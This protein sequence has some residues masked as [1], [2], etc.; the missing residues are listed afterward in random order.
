MNFDILESV[1]Q[2]RRSCKP[3]LMNG[4][5]ID[6]SIIYKLL[7]LADWAPTHAHTEPWRFIVFADDKVQ[8]FCRDHA[9]LYKANIPQEKFETSKY[10]KILHNGDYCSHIIAVYMQ[11]GNNPKIT[12]VE[13]ICAVAAS[14][15]NLLLGASCLNIAALWSTGGVTYHAAMK[16]YFYL[17]DEDQ[18]IGLIYLGYTD[19]EPKKGERI[20]SLDKKI[21]WRS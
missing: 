17:K 1:I 6:D 10:E 9:E 8:Q 21:E 3:V 5:K 13:E 20:V 19:Q 18:M 11:R 15:Q 16:K 2:N 12:T 14:V 4:E 7:Q